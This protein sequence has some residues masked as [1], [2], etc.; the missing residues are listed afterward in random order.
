MKENSQ[1]EAHLQ[2]S[3]I[4]GSTSV[5]DAS[6]FIVPERFDLGFKLLWLECS[7]YR[8]LQAEAGYEAH[9][10]AITEFTE[11]EYGNSSKSG[12][13]S[14]KKQFKDLEE[15][16]EKAFDENISTIPIDKNGILLN[17]AH[18]TSIAV[19]NKISVS[20][21]TCDY[22]H[23]NY[24][25]RFFHKRGVRQDYLIVQLEQFVEMGKIF[26]SIRWPAAGAENDSKISALLPKIMYENK[27]L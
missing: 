16:M 14:F 12:V 8:S 11:A 6:D 26:F 15:S 10:K 3:V 25:W 1:I 17:G 22:P 2:K 4:T 18:R 20:A 7:K 13:V 19:K 24:D 9:I 23:P 21:V 5:Y 27:L